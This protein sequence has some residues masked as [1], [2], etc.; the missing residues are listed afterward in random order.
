MGTPGLRSSCAKWAARGISK[1]AK[2]L[3]HSKTS[4]L[5]NSWAWAMEQTTV[6]GWSST[7]FSPLSWHWKASRSNNTDDGLDSRRCSASTATRR[8]SRYGRAAVH[9]WWLMMVEAGFRGA[10][11]QS[12]ANEQWSAQM[13]QRWRWRVRLCYHLVSRKIVPGS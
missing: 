8:W 4:L 9:R 11:L 10:G 13:R 3:T 1:Y 12:V 5:K 7:S 2:T 6:H